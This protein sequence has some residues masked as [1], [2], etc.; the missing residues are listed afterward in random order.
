[1]LE[2]IIKSL[3]RYS[4]KMDFCRPIARRL[5][6]SFHWLK[7]HRQS[8]LTDWAAALT[9]AEARDMPYDAARSHHMLAEHLPKGELRRLHHLAAAGALYAQL[10]ASFDLQTLERLR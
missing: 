5:R 8:A 7:G 10:D 9:A 4:T 1:M 2:G 3:E 6:G